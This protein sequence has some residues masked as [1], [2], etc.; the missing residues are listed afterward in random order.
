M[1]VLNS[2]SG[3]PLSLFDAVK[4]YLLNLLVWCA[5]MFVFVPGPNVPIIVMKFGFGKYLFVFKLLNINHPEI[6]GKKLAN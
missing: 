4:I 3:T 6:F 5:I 2:I 1:E